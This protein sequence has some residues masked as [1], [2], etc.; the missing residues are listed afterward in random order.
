[1]T[2]AFLDKSA[3]FAGDKSARRFLYEAFSRLLI[4]VSDSL[5]IPPE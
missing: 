1:M 4:K 2:T 5:E 3:C